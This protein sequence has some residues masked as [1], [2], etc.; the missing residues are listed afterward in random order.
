MAA[1]ADERLLRLVR[2]A[3]EERQRRIRAERAASALRAFHC[4]G[5]GEPAAST[6]TQMATLPCNRPPL[7]PTRPKYS[8]RQS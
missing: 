6:A 2:Q 5:R 7:E 1:A 4:L 3:D 8:W